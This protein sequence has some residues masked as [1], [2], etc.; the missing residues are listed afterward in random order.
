L[1][2]NQRDRKILHDSKEN[3]NA[4]DGGRSKK[5][6]RQGSEDIVLGGKPLS[7]LRGVT[8]TQV[9]YSS[10][11]SSFVAR[12]KNHHSH[13]HHHHHSGRKGKDHMP[14]EFKKIN[15]TTFDVAMKKA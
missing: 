4:V 14:E 11:P 9:N 2:A 12:R 3:T 10:K 7:T 8:S 1:S 5:R 6:H 13:H 15:P